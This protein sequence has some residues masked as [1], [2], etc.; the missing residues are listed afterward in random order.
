VFPADHEN[1]AIPSNATTR[2]ASAVGMRSTILCVSVLSLAGV[3][4]VSLR[5]ASASRFVRRP[6]ALAATAAVTVVAALR[7]CV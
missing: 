5:P 2:S 1:S 7:S 6:P 3:N 4:S